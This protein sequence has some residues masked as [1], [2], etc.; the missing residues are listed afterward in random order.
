M[1][2]VLLTISLIA[3]VSFGQVLVQDT[4]SFHGID[5]GDG[6]GTDN[7][8]IQNFGGGKYGFEI[9]TTG[10]SATGSKLILSYGT[11]TETDIVGGGDRGGAPFDVI[12]YNGAGLTEALTVSDFNLSTGG[13]WYLDGVASDGILRLEMSE[14]DYLSNQITDFGVGLYAVDGLKTGV[15]DTAFGNPDSAA[16]VTVNTSSGFVVQ[17]A[18][19]NNQSLTPNG[20]DAWLTNYDW[21]SNSY[22]GLQQYQVVSAAGDYFAPTS[23]T[24]T[25]LVMGGAFEAVPEPSSFALLAGMFGLTWVMLRRRS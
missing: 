19:R 24:N 23:N 9:D 18:I 10:F 17:E 5:I 7:I 14:A 20:T 2:K 25:K 13:I 15:Q 12:T 22:Q 3:N 6:D 16:T 11:K 8:S 4:F 21:S 1:K